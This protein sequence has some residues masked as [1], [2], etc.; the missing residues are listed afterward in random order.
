MYLPENFSY[1]PKHN[2]VF[3]GIDLG[4]TYTLVAVVNSDDLKIDESFEIPVKFISFKQKSPIKHGGE[5][6]DEKVASIIAI[7]EGKP[8]CGSKLYELKGNENFIKNVNIF[9][10]WKLDLGIDRHPLYP[11]AISDDLNTPAKVASKVLNFCRNEYT[12][13]KDARLFNTVIT[14][15]ASFQMNQR[16]DVLKAAELANIEVTSKMLIDE[17]NAAFIGHFNSLQKNEKQRIF[18]TTKPQNVLIFDFG[19]G[20]CDL[21][22]LAVSY[23]PQKGLMVGNKAISRYNDLG[24]QDIDCI[25]AEEI[26]YP[27]W[28]KLAN[29]KDD[30]PLKDLSEII[31]PQLSTIG[32]LYKKAICER[33]L[34]KFPDLNWKENDLKDTFE[35]INGRILNY[36]GQV[37]NLDNIK[38]TGYEISEIINKLYFGKGYR[39]KY[40]DKLI[41]AIS[42]TITEIIEKANITK[43]DIDFVLT[44]GGSSKNPFIVK[45][46][47]ED[48]VNSIIWQPSK[49]DKLVAQGAAIYSFFYFGFNKSIINPICSDTIGIETKNNNFYTLIEKG[50]ELPF[51][52]TLPNFKLQNN[53]A[54]SII[55]PIC[56]NTTDYIIQELVIPL[57]KEY[58][59]ESIVQID[60]T[61]DNNKVLSLEIK[62]NN[63]KI[64]EYSLENPFFIGSL[65]KEQIKFV[66]ITKDLDNAKRANNANLERRLILELLSQYF[67]I[68]NYHE[69]SILSEQYLNKFDSNNTTVLNYNYI[70]NKGIGRIEAAQKSLNKAINIE[71]NEP[72]FRYNYSILVQEL[73]GIQKALDYLENLSVSLKNDSSIKCRIVVLKH[74]LGIDIKSDASKIANEYQ[75]N[76]NN[77]SSHDQKHLLRSIFNFVDIPYKF[78]DSKDDK[79]R[80]SKM[81]TLTNNLIKL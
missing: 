14:V 26:L 56:I 64:L 11:D 13:N 57:T 4:T 38:I 63:E 47:K 46:L 80:D 6:I 50:T 36:K 62:I 12:K 44:V 16:N 10:H 67:E 35:V 76:P 1:K 60:A 24:G 72:A 77:F 21:S 49:P 52:A 45:L 71:P 39:L 5:I 27:K 51:K 59:N 37:Y 48:F 55:I 9:Y 69:I 23:S 7:H 34:A 41:K 33:I 2:D 40:Q 15:P 17:P 8:Y 30:L 20:T 19:G 75:N 58:D 73:E 54:E 32:E 70:G 29:F 43:Y 81:L 74:Q 61:L 25:I 65:S 3:F 68:K 42:S 28:L 22:I 79:E 53:F 66:K 31:L 78:T 18:A